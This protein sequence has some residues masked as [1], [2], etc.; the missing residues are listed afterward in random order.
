VSR[1]TARTLRDAAAHL[2]AHGWTQGRQFD[3]QRACLVGSLRRA[4][5]LGLQMWTGPLQD[6]HDAVARHLRDVPVL[7]NDAP[8][9]TPA[10]V[11]K[12]LLT[13]ADLEDVA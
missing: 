13:V 9:R 6:A 7:W 2:E 1:S 4:L 3:G 12:E 10:E 5:G 11:V 8:G